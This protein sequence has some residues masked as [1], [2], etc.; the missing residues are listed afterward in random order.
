MRILRSCAV[1]LFLALSLAIDALPAQVTAQ[2][3]PYTFFLTRYELGQSMDMSKLERVAYRSDGEPF[4]KAPDGSTVTMSG[5]GA[6]EP[7]SKRATGGGQYAIKDPSGA[8]R[9]Q[10]T[11]RVTSL[12]SFQKIPG[13]WNMPGLKE[14]GWQGP[15][16]S[17]T[18][19]GILKVNVSLDNLG[20]GVLETWCLMPGVTK[21]GDHKS[22]GISLTGGTFNFLDYH[23]NEMGPH[24]VMFYSTD[25]ASDGMVLGAD[26]TTI[27]RAGSPSTLPATGEYDGSTTLIRTL[28][29]AAF[30]LALIGA[31]LALGRRTV[32]D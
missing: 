11:W 20:D 17:T 10:G 6:W 27:F 19:S 15:S 23:D 5:Q 21:P 4:A 3:L 32:Q 7:N 30:G 2:D 22:D 29:L 31:G 16:G 28:V 9:S 12:V 25:P 1:A 26:G 8:V 14:E 18:F 13:W 24:G